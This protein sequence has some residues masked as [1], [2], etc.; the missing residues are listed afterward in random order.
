M[1]FEVVTK[2]EGIHRE[3]AEGLE[4]RLDCFPEI[5]LKQLKH[6]VATSPIPILF[7]FRGL[8]SQDRI[9]ELLAVKPHF[10]DFEQDIDRSFIE[11][12]TLLHPEVKLISSYH[13]FEKTPKDLSEILRGMESPHFYAYKIAVMAQT[14]LDALRMMVFVKEQVALSK[15]ISGIC[16]G[17]KGQLTR[18][19]GR[20][21]G[22]FI[23]YAGS[24]APGQLK[25]Q[26]L[27]DIYN[28]RSLTPSTSIYGLIGN[29]IS[30]SPGHFAHNGVMR[31]LKLDGV[32][33]KIPL[34]PEE[35]SEFF[36]LARE[37][38]IK[39]LSVTIPLKEEVMGYLDEIDEEANEI[40]AVNTISCINGKWHGFNTDG[41]G[42]LDA[43]ERRGPIRGKKLVLIG[44][45]GS[46][47][48]I[49]YTAAVR[50][51]ELMVLNRTREKALSLAGRYHGTGGGMDEICADYDILVNTA[52]VPL[53][54]DPLPGALV[55]DIRVGGEDGS[56]KEM[57]INQAALQEE[58]WFG[59]RAS[60]KVVTK[61]LEAENRAK[62][63]SPIPH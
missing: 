36:S 54:I 5:D 21:Y 48:A 51:A 62:I 31:K 2:M 37:L 32:Y 26:E 20:I 6:L 59:Q 43:I 1:L 4:L 23:D 27:Y 41:R 17:E 60:A 63:E 16:M 18:I 13:D 10:F 61:L 12:M 56:W 9:E 34:D 8:R 29:P 3:G 19:L 11:K 39:G 46:A 30:K 42:A 7:T 14:S 55:M 35:L 25:L 44:T 15:R 33:V 58:I 22:N 50:G 53:P 45:G 40:G 57:F 52:P 47:K 38:G 28:Y 49:A 24:I